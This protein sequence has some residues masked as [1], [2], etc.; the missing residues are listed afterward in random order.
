MHNITVTINKTKSKANGKLLTRNDKYTFLTPL[1]SSRKFFMV[2]MAFPYYLQILWT[3]L[4]HF[5]TYQENIDYGTFFYRSLP[6]LQCV[7]QLHQV[8]GTQA[9]KRGTSMSSGKHYSF[10][11][12][13]DAPPLQPHLSQNSCM[14]DTGIQHS[15]KDNFPIQYDTFIQSNSVIMR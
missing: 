1:S 4:H 14:L 8:S 9:G 3:L 10:F 15:K 6:A 12:T 7:I 2:T 13:D 5:Q 11:Q